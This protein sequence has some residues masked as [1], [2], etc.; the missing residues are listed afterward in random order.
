MSTEFCR[1]CYKRFMDRVDAMP[2]TNYHVNP[3]D[4]SF[5]CK[6]PIHTSDWN[7]NPVVRI[8]D[9]ESMKES[10]ISLEEYRSRKAAGEL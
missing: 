5:S 10:T 9:C 2:G 1:R 4:M 3:G 7:G 8:W 6:I